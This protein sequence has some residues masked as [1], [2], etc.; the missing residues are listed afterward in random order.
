MATVTRETRLWQIKHQIQD[1]ISEAASL[2]VGAVPVNMPT[3]AP[4][5]RCQA[6][7]MVT[8]VGKSLTFRQAWET[9]TGDTCGFTVECAVTYFSAP[10]V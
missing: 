4:T 3:V 2:D 9:S 7:Y 5:T 1:L 10:K 8:A 6:V